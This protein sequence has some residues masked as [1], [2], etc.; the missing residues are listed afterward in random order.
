MIGETISHYQ[1]LEKLGEGGMGVVYKAR[2]LDLDRHVAIK[3]L[4]P[5]MVADE[6]ATKR[7]THEA[8][9]ASALNHPN[10]GVVHEI[11]RSDDGLTFMVMA[12]Y[13]GESLRERIDRGAM[14]FEEALDITAQ[15]SSGLVKAHEHGIVHRDIKPNNVLLTEDGHAVIIDFGLAKLAGGTKLTRAGYTLGTAAYMSPEQARG[16][17]VDNRSDIF[18]LGVMLYEMLAGE[19]PFRG[20][21]EAAVVYEIVHEE[22]EPL[23]DCGRLLPAGAGQVMER[24]LAKDRE[25]R[26]ESCAELLK[27]IRAMQEGSRVSAIERRTARKT[28]RRA[29]LYAAC[30]IV[31]AAAVYFAA[32]RLV[33]M[34]G[35]DDAVPVDP[36]VFAVLPFEVRGGGELADL[37]DGMV[38][39]LSKKLDGAGELRSVD[40]R[41]LITHVRRQED[42]MPAAELGRSVAE[43]FGAG[44]YLLGD[45]MAAGDQVHINASLYEAGGGASSVAEATVEGPEEQVFDLVDDLAIQLLISRLRNR[46]DFRY[47]VDA[48]STESFEALKAFLKGEAAFRRGGGLGIAIDAFQMAVDEDSM[49]AHAWC[50]LAKAVWWPMKDIY[51]ARNAADKA[52]HYGEN[53]PEREL[54]RAKALRAVLYM[55]DDEAE[56]LYRTLVTNYPRD[57]EAW[58]SLGAF[59]LFSSPRRG[60]SLSGAR[61]ALERALELDPDEWQSLYH[62]AAI[63]AY[64]HK[65]EENKSLLYRRAGGEELPLKDRAQLA[66]STGDR[67]EQEAVIEEMRELDDYT[68]MI[69]IMRIAC[70]TDDIERA[71]D[72]VRLISDSDRSDEM[73]GVGHI[74]LAYL[75]TARGR[76]RA[77]A[78]EFDRAGQLNPALAI[79]YEALALAMPF[80]PVSES[81]LTAIEAGLIEWDADAVPPSIG[82]MPFLTVHNDLHPHLRVYLLGLVNIRLGDYKEALGYVVELERMEGPPHVTGLTKG[83]AHGLRAQLA[84]KEGDTGRAL[85]QFEK[86]RVRSP[87]RYRNFSQFYKQQ[88][89]RFLKAELL[90]E[91]GRHE[92]A[93][94]WTSSFGIG[95][96]F[97]FIYRAVIHLR[98]AEN[99]ERLGQNDEAI[100]QY[101]KFIDCWKDCD[102]ELRPM[103]DEVQKKLDILKTAAS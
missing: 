91:M 98:Q 20:E 74:L 67:A 4:P 47:D 5:H 94:G 76:L 72:T 15:V 21:H 84:W 50:R 99:H 60:C 58:H 19:K 101:S 32:T 64:E 75:E 87:P 26:Y 88:H 6:E 63:A 46:N 86:G 38:D 61:E 68:L 36:S 43:K 97:S 12:C 80:L 57:V 48:L 27:D 89:E 78:M 40:P 11:G 53:L 3:F 103:V 33:P 69:C 77:A 100:E 10:I 82:D 54:L 41:A 17:E 66:F 42:G 34:I 90:H 28:H 96:N 85:E 59:L 16:E 13:E 23:E 62:L 95:W 31:I 83:L 79:E 9:A 30:G 39:L 93:L 14:K 45:I 81:D 51:R 25:D 29:L 35:T 49:F 7:F 52:V 2:D 24:A 8:R 55:E 65:Y 70:W 37:G 71:Q 18:S 1:I 56:Q 73:R 102:E 44:L 22:P 92:E